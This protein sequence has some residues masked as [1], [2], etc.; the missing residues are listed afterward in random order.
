MP[1][2]RFASHCITLELALAMLPSPRPPEPFNRP[3]KAN[4]LTR[5]DLLDVC[6]TGAANVRLGE[7]VRSTE[8]ANDVAVFPLQRQLLPFACIYFFGS[9]LWC[10]PST[11]CGSSNFV[12]VLMTC[13]CDCGSGGLPNRDASYTPFSESATRTTRIR[14]WK[15]RRQ[16][17]VCR[18]RLRSRT[19]TLWCACCR[20]SDARLLLVSST[21]SSPTL[22]AK[23]P[24]RTMTARRNSIGDLAR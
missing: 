19:G 12:M 24:G 15:L 14:R 22:G 2:N 18:R 17:H 1:R 23:S 7:S 10:S 8:V 9:D 5:F 11:R 20:V 13:G 4:F 21:A 3:V 16:L 6:S